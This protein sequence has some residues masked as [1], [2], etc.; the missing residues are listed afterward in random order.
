MSKRTGICIRQDGHGR[1]GV[2]V[3]PV[4][5]GWRVNELDRSTPDGQLTK[6]LLTAAKKSG[7]PVTWLLP[8]AEVSL[9]HLNMPK[10][11]A[12]ALKRAFLG[13][14]ARDEGGKPE[15]W[16]VTW[17]QLAKPAGRGTQT[18]FPHILHY[19]ARDVVE[20]DLAV[21]R[22]WGVDVQRMLPGHLALD[23]F[24]RTH[25]PDHGEHAVW[26]LV[27]VGQQQHFL[28]VATSDAQL[29]IRNL[30]ANLSGDEDIKEYLSR[31]ATEIERSAFFARQTEHSPEVEKIIVC[32]DPNFAAPLVD[33]LGESSS[34]PA[35]HW[36]IEDMFHWGSNEQNADD[37]VAL[38][39]AVLSLQKIPF[40]LLP[41]RGQLHLSRGARRKML[42]AATTCATA[43]VPVL[44][45]GGLVT[46]RI[47]GTY[48]ERAQA[49]L[50]EAQTKAG[51]AE[52]AYEAQRVL[53]SREDQ[54]RHFAR[55]RPDF[56]SVLLRLA[57]LTPTEITFKDLQIREQ[58]V[59]RFRLRLHGESRSATGAR[60][61]SAFLEFLAALD[62]SR[63]LQRQGDPRVMQIKPGMDKTD[64]DKTTVFQIDLAW[65]GP[66]KGDR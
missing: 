51:Q 49:R 64:A 41:D 22:A 33:V 57:A 66:D 38:A 7:S 11:R 27:F 53:L 35:I 45:V 6:N 39:G 34:I 56:E 28:C 61:Q 15:N 20:R 37:L 3:S 2:S 36:P 8:D 52:K 42:I 54:I 40:N 17:K 12:K 29:M 23:L 48:L 30:P 55:S 63:F 10:L 47:Q 62:G 43:A 60:A 13:G 18:S 16:C 1:V 4:G 14:L 5:P 25:G 32:G 9:A 59:G 44:L 46:A 58:E 19:A 26:N 31:L 65:R 50:A 24:Y 21:A